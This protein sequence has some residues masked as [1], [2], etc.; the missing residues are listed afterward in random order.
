MHNKRYDYIVV[1]SGLFGSVFAH[2]M[3]ARGKSCLVLEK[4]S[5]PGGNIRCESRDGIR[6]HVY[7]AHIFHTNN[8][9]TWTYI[10]Q[11]SSFNNFKNSPIANFNGRLFNLPFNMNTFY[12]LWGTK[13]PAEARK[14]IELQRGELQDKTPE[15]LQEQAISL[16]GREL[17]EMLI[18]GYT[19]KQ[20]G[21]PCVDLPASIIK[22]IPVRYTFDNNYFNDRFQ[23]IPV[24]GY[25]AIIEK[26]LAGC[27]VRYNTDFNAD[28]E[29]Y[30][31]L[32]DKVL[33][34]GTLDAY[35]DYRLGEL[36]F[37][38]ERFEHERLEVANY[39]GVA[40][41]N[42]T[43]TSTPY[44]RIVEHK[45]FE[46]G[47]QPFTWISYEF[48]FEYGKDHEPF[49][50]IE[51]SYNLQLYKEYRFMADKEANLLI[52]GRLAEYRYYDMDKIIE[53]ALDLVRKEEEKQ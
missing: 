22:R 4:R 16:V 35:F 1:G 47:E 21:R 30:R 37:R 14:M 50:P 34:T 13:T 5:V 31:D 2:E 11:F 20:W 39:Q 24:E 9:E 17:Y 33:Y 49:Y 28:K 53:S 41:M 15:N 42:F 29:N 46:F 3:V 19:E 43:D 52:G 38:S 27:E 25:N 26:M 23:G 45:H 44:T 36:Q 10:N 6:I 32:A 12:Q 51:N 18:K 8:P 48:P 40:V 7:G